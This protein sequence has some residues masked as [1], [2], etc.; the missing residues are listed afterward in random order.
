MGTRAVCHQQKDSRGRFAGVHP[1]AGL[2]DSAH[3]NFGR[4]GGRAIGKLEH[5]SLMAEARLEV[6]ASISATVSAWFG[7]PREAD[8]DRIRC[9]AILSVRSQSTDFDSIAGS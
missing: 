5:T 6:K 3:P 2:I 7:A 8:S 4:S 1:K 9:I